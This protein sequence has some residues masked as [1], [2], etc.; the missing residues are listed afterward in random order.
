[1]DLRPFLEISKVVL[2]VDDQFLF[3]RALKDE[4]EEGGYQVLDVA[5]RRQQALSYARDTRPDLALVNLDLAHGD[6]GI[7]LAG[8]LKAIDI[9]VMF[10]S[11]P[12]ERSSQAWKVAVAS[13]ARP[14]EPAEVVPAVD[15]LFR[16]ERGDESAPRPRTLEMLDGTRH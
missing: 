1:M 6:D 8:D 14:H 11:G 13:L 10:I 4:L 2:L 3:A 15:Y 7:A 9:P 5:M 12:R 16:H